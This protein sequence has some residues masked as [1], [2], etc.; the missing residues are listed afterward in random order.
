MY[1][2]Y[3][4]DMKFATLAQSKQQKSWLLAE[5]KSKKCFK[6]IWLAETCKESELFEFSFAWTNSMDLIKS[7]NMWLLYI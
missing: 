4:T 3:W 1:H 6:W 2:L 7:E 5:G